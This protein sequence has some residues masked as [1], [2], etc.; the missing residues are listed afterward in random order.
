MLSRTLVVALLALALAPPAATAG[1]FKVQGST[2]IYTANAGEEDKIAAFEMGDRVRFTRFGGGSL[3]PDAGCTLSN[4]LQSVVCDK[5]GVSSV[6]L[7]L[8]DG[9]DV[10]AISPSVTLTVV[11][12]GGAGNDGLFGGSGPDI[13]LGGPGDDNLVSRDSRAGETV[14]CGAGTDTAISDDGDVRALCERVEDDA[15][16]DGVRRPADCNDT[17]PAIVPGAA[18]V[19]DNGVDENCDGVDATEL[20]RDRDGIP[21]PQDCNDAD[22]AIRP[23]AREVI[24][25][26]VDENCDTRIEPFPPV[27][28][29]LSNGWTPAGSGTRN[30]LLVARRFPRG[31]VVTVSCRG[32]GCPFGSFRRTIRRANENL[33]TRFGDAVL[34]RNTRVDVRITRENRVGRLLRFRMGTPGQPT[35]AF[36]CLPPGGRARDC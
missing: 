6:V 24:G 3:G 22:A 32:G 36:Q 15:D 33:H 11:M 23:T 10:A 9:A 27:L 14:D 13:F 18:D 28:G 1:T 5:A 19:P 8:G 21:R 20:D 12:D 2:I 25:N 30:Q 29:S 7:N 35:V 31:T 26:A 4:D 16:L 17:N 34:A